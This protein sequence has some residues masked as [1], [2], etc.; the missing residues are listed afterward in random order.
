MVCYGTFVTS[1]SNL[2]WSLRA[3]NWNKNTEQPSIQQKIVFNPLKVFKRCSSHMNLWTSQFFYNSHEMNEIVLLNHIKIG[4]MT[5]R[6]MFYLS[7]WISFITYHTL[8]RECLKRLLCE[9]AYRVSHIEMDKV[10]WL[11]QVS[12]MGYG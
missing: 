10:D 5:F 2:C 9:I 8:T 4:V 7:N 6:R 1:N 3:Q 12:G 11:W